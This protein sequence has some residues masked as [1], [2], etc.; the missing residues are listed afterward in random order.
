MKS[1]Q[2]EYGFTLIELMIATMVFSVILL[3]AAVAMVQ[4]GRIYF[5]GIT[6]A[7]TQEVS[8]TISDDVAQAIQFSGA[9][10]K[11]IQKPPGSNALGF[12]V[13]N[14]RYSYLVN[15]QLEQN[16]ATSPPLAGT[17]AKHVLVMDDTTKLPAPFNCTSS[18]YAQAIDGAGSIYGREL[19]GIHMRLVSDPLPQPPL[20][21]SP[22][23]KLYTVTVGVV[24]GDWDVLNVTTIP[25]PPAGSNY[26]YSCKASNKG[27][28]F[29][30]VSSLTTTVEKRVQ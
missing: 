18:T 11:T 10:I 17:Q 26:N 1:Q 25:P 14:I 3:L 24:Y 12:C 16:P 22:D 7:K 8:R 4:I 5:K 2:R 29:C 15:Q 6:A 9:Q 21:I 23:G 30:S 27:G 28:Q 20:P 19:M 13:D